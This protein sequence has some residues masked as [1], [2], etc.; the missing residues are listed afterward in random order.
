MDNMLLIRLR[1]GNLTQNEAADAIESLQLDLARLCRSRDRKD[2]IN[3][4][5]STEVE[6]LKAENAKLRDLLFN[7][8]PY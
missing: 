5:L 7:E 4:E 1:A 2:K 6:K 8:S 3:G